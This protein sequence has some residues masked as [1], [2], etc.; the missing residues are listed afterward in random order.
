MWKLCFF[1]FFLCCDSG[2]SMVVDLSVLIPWV[3]SKV[4]GLNTG[5]RVDAIIV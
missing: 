2:R 5:K 4:G 1:L 3:V